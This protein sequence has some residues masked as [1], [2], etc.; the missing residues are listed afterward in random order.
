M[1][2]VCEMRGQVG[3]GAL[4]GDFRLHEEAE[5][6]DHGQPRVLDLLHLQRAQRL[7][8][9]LGQTERIENAARVANLS[10]GKLVA[11]ENGVRRC[12]SLDVRRGS[13]QLCTLLNKK[14]TTHRVLHVLESAQL[15]KVKENTKHKEEG[16]GISKTKG[17]SSTGFKRGHEIAPRE[18]AA[19]RTSSMFER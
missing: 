13:C 18:G 10:S 12:R 11:R 16:D 17:R 14:I 9:A 6:R 7:R 19:E 1:A 15:H 5:H 4:A 3:N 2:R 8:A